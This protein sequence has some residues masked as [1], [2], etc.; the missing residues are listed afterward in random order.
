MTLCQEEMEQALK[1]RAQEQEE[2]KV[3]VVLVGETLQIRARAEDKARAKNREEVLDRDRAREEDKARAKAMER[4]VV[5]DNHR[6]T[7]KK[8]G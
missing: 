8:R 3:P 1:E 6:K 4:A 7:I 5:N 2:E